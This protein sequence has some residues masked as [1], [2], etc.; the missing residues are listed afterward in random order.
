MD[1]IHDT[2]SND[3]YYCANKECVCHEVRRSTQWSE[4]HTDSSDTPSITRTA[5][6][7]KSVTNI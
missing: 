1:S 6:E 4:I 2:D 5:S 3:Y 7:E